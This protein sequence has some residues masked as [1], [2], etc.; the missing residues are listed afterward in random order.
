MTQTSADRYA[1][2]RWFL[3]HGL[4]AVVRRRALV[5][6]VWGRSAPALAVFAVISLN[7]IAIVVVTGQHTV[8]IPGRPDLAEGVVLALVALVLPIATLAG[9]LV[10]RLT[11]PLQRA[12][13]A[14]VALAAIVVGMIFGGPSNRILVN[15]FSA[16]ITLT[17]ILVVTASG[18]GSV[19]GFLLYVTRTNLAFIG[20]MF[21]RALPVVLLTF[22]V[23]FNGPVWQMTA[24]IS[25][26]RLWA[27]MI[28]LV[29]IAASFLVS[30]TLDRVRPMLAESTPTL[31]GDETLEDTPF[32]QIPDPPG[33]TP[34]SRSERVNVVFVVA[35]SQVSQVLTVAMLTGAIFVVF[36]LII[37]SPETLD[38]W[39]RGAGRPDGQLLGMTLP[40]PDALLQTSMLL[41]A[42]TFMY[43]SAKAVS[44]TAYRAQFIEPLID[45]LRQTLVARNRYRS[46]QP[47]R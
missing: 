36:G 26:P 10:S 12:M 2:E 4:P 30:T 13:A 41:A 39:T 27:G 8:D 31:E 28:F 43:L 6:R 46:A 22:L 37:L 3:V 38:A 21:V 25:R 40:V 19:L 9:W 17:L 47:K 7:S 35:A 11:N 24:V 32:A 42:I 14:N 1:E 23:F 44:D 29:L 18:A 34:L 20:G 45:E 5:S 33:G 16:A 15:L